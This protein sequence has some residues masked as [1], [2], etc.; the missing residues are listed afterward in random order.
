LRFG[1]GSIDGLRLVGPIQVASGRNATTFKALIPSKAF[2]SG[3][4]VLRLSGEAVKLGAPRIELSA[5][6]V[7]PEATELDAPGGS[8]SRV[9]K[10]ASGQE[11]RAVVA[12]AQ[13]TMWQTLRLPE[14]E[15]Y[16]GNPGKGASSTRYEYVSARPT[17]RRTTPR[18]E[19]L[20]TGA[21][22]LT[23]LA[24]ALVIRNAAVLW[25]RS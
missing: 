24:A 23:L 1:S 11:R 4:V 6:P 15:A 21:L 19:G 25:A 16:L 7:M 22:L 9:L 13:R 8:W 14:F 5:H 20:K 10:G 17:A 18:E 3:T 2:P 12:L